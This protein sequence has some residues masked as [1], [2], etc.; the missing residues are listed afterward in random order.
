MAL[1]FS[2]NKRD[3][4]SI[5]K[6]MPNNLYSNNFIKDLIDYNF[7]DVYLY[8]KSIPYFGIDYMA[9]KNMGIIEPQISYA[10][11]IDI[12]K[13]FTLINAHYKTNC[14]LTAWAEGIQLLKRDYLMVNTKGY[15][16]DNSFNII[17]EYVKKTFANNGY[18]C[19]FKIIPSQN[20]GY[21]YNIAIIVFCTRQ[22]FNGS[23]YYP[24]IDVS[25]KKREILYNQLLASGGCVHNNSIS[26]EPKVEL[27]DLYIR[28]KSYMTSEPIHTIEFPIN[29]G[30]LISGISMINNKRRKI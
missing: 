17:K 14:C 24:N 21:N 19:A 10:S 8:D 13:E 25:N 22:V 5:Y 20:I 3:T 30:P 15:F 4:E 29:P 27:R 16:I 18:L 28:Y 9:Q 11:P 2:G 12:I 7:S 6:I 1:I 23:Y 26:K